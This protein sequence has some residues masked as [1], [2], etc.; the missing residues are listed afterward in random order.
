V[1]A[2]GTSELLIGLERK[3]NPVPFST[4]EIVSLIGLNPVSLWKCDNARFAGRGLRP[5]GWRSN[6]RP[7][8][9]GHDET[10]TTRARARTTV[11]LFTAGEDG[12]RSFA[13]LTLSG[14]DVSMR[15]LPLGRGESI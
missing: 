13:E 6:F 8:Q 3:R 15:A 9:F 4:V 10:W 7:V 14:G 2:D 5:E 12:A 11:F 1:N